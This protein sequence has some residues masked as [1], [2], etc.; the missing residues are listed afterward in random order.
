M[1]V[2]PIKIELTWE[3]RRA[4]EEIAVQD[5]RKPSDML[6]W[7]LREELNRRQEKHNGA[8]TNLNGTNGAVAA[9]AG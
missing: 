6:R 2:P 9:I 8:V 4:L 7:L 3:E 5:M 1:S